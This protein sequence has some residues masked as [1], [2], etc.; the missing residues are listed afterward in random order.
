MVVDDKGIDF[1]P[2]TLELKC[3][4]VNDLLAVKPES[5]LACLNIS[6]L[7]GKMRYVIHW[8]IIKIK[9]D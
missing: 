8:V 6:L 7:N 5:P 2:D 9:K 3:W 4:L 1:W